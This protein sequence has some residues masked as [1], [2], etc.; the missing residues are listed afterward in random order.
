MSDKEPQLQQKQQ[1]SEVKK[2]GLVNIVEENRKRRRSEQVDEEQPIIQTQDPSLPIPPSQMATH[3]KEEEKKKERD[4]QLEAKKPCLIPGHPEIRKEGLIKI[5]LKPGLGDPKYLSQ[6]KQGSMLIIKQWI[7][8]SKNG[9]CGYTL[10][11]VDDE[12]WWSDAATLDSLKKAEVFRITSTYFYYIVQKTK[13]GLQYYWYPKDNC[14]EEEKTKMND[15]IE[16]KV[17]N[18]IFPPPPN[19]HPN[20]IANAEEINDDDDDDDEDSFLNAVA[21]QLANQD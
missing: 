6:L 20:Q 9:K 18:A 16:N 15:M 3:G 21:T 10:F 5:N 2:K 17:E 13:R 14:P 4:A 19:P 7:L 11:D 12:K 8:W 1:K